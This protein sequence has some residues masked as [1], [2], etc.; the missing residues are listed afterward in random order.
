V[1]R[2]LQRI[3]SPLMPLQV[4]L[5]LNATRTLDDLDEEFLKR[6]PLT[7]DA[8]ALTHLDEVTKWGR[9]A[10]WLLILDKP[11]HFVSTGRR[12]PE[13]VEAFTPSWFVEEMMHL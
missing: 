10:E 3:V 2:R 6:M 9:I 11:V 4:H 5:T 7:P 13:G 8:V 12:V 1:L